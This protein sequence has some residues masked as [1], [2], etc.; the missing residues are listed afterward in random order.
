MQGL[1]VFSDNEKQLLFSPNLLFI[2]AG[3]KIDERLFFVPVDI[4]G[5]CQN[6]AYL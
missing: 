4:D 3:I 1:I 5:T 6:V 2:P